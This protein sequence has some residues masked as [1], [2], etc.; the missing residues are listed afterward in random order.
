[1]Q[2]LFTYKSMKE[3]Y[4][5][6]FSIGFLTENVPNIIAYVGYFASIIRACRVVQVREKL[7]TNCEQT[8]NKSLTT[9]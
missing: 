1:M 7:L 8:I 5:L 9:P 3:K 2:G 6:L 4:A